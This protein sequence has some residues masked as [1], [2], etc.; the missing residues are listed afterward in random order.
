[1]FNIRTTNNFIA[2]LGL[3]WLWEDASLLGVKIT[4]ID[5]PNLPFLNGSTSRVPANS[6]LIEHILDALSIDAPS[7]SH[8][9]KI[10]I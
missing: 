5:S 8:E 2:S 6:D 7:F 1:M 9:G 4:F 10:R 3:Y